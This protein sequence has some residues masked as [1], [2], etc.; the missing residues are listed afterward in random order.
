[1]RNMSLPLF[2]KA[3]AQGDR[4]AIVDEMPRNA[5]GKVIKPEL[6]NMF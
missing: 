5:M 2:D 4:L 1:M 3:G 6:K